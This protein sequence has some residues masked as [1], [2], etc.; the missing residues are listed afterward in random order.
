[1][2]LSRSLLPRLPAT[3]S[4]IRTSETASL[5]ATTE[6]PSR[7][8]SIR[9]PEAIY[10][11]DTCDIWFDSLILMYS[12]VSIPAANWSASTWTE[13]REILTVS[14]TAFFTTNRIFRQTVRHHR[15]I[16]G[17]RRSVNFNKLSSPPRWIPPLLRPR[18][19]SASR[20][21]YSPPG[22]SPP[23]TITIAARISVNRYQILPRWLAEDRVPLRTPVA[24]SPRA[25]M[26]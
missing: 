10:S 11:C 15:R 4:R 19:H 16:S 12:A 5:V 13:I 26:L 9:V 20:Q 1:M 8:N 6:G 21:Q 24:R 23:P 7:R 3:T 22:P 2:V 17:R 18:S 25:R 14:N